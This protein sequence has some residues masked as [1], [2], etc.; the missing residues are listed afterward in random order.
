MENVLQFTPIHSTSP[1]YGFCEQLYVDAFPPTERR[2]NKEQ[3]RIIDQESRFFFCAIR[4]EEKT[5]GFLSY[6][7][8]DTFIYIEHFAIDA[9]LRGQNIGSRLLQDFH[10]N[11]TLPIIL[12]VERPET[13]IARR[14]IHFYERCG[15]TLWQSDYIQPPYQAGY[16]SLPLYLMCH[17]DLTEAKD[18]DHIRQ[19]L[20][21]EVYHF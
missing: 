17:G 14:R 8:F 3:R 4:K 15:Y 21:K 11:M 19:T 16:A 5:V 6:W 7:N 1:D 13:P 2:T 9:S 12:E 10:N 20:Y 18:F